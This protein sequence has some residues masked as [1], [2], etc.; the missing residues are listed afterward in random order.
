MC[1]APQGRAP[2][3]GDQELGRL[4]WLALLFFRAF[5]FRAF[6]AMLCL[7][8]WSRSGRG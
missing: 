8:C 6:F 5:F 1:P 3:I 4:P 2:L 7:L